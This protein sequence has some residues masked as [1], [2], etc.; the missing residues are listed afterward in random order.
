MDIKHRRPQHKT[1]YT[2]LNSVLIKN[3]KNTY[4]NNIAYMHIN[5]QVGLWCNIDLQHAW[6]VGKACPVV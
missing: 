5:W 6:W 1:Y 3:N 4:N 2:L